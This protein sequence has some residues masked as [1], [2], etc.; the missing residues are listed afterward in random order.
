ARR[1][2]FNGCRKHNKAEDPRFLYW[3]DRL[4]FLVWS[5][6]PSAYSDGERTRRALASQLVGQVE[7]D[8]NH[9]ALMAWVL[10]NESWGIRDVSRSP[11]VRDWVRELAGLARRLDPTR[12]VISNDGWEHVDS[13]LYTFHTYAPDPAT[14]VGDVRAFRDGGRVGEHRL[15]AEEGRPGSRPLVASEIGGIGFAPGAI[16]RGGWGYA[17]I[18]ASAEELER[19]MGD[20]LDA[21][22]GTEGLA[23]FCYTQLTDTEQEINGLLTA[24]RAAKIPVAKI[25][26]IITGKE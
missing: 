8:R 2:G 15:L 4:G 22:R 5:E 7:R 14:F 23:G 11:E 16:P 13:D 3:A 18:A 26:K 6:V 19:R 21:V 1:L 12:L 17:R 25:R 9:P 20:L 10:Y 24:E